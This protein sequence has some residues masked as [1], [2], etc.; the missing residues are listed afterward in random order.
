M[1]SRP[2]RPAL[3]LV[4][5]ADANPGTEPFPSRKLYQAIRGNGGTTRLVVLPDEPH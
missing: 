1:L 4:A 5:L 3:A 2:H